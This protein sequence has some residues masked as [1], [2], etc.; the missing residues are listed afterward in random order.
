MASKAAFSGKTEEG[1]GVFGLLFF[2][3]D[4]GHLV[5][6]QKGAQEQKR[7]REIERR[8]VWGSVIK[9]TFSTLQ[10]RKKVI[11]HTHT[12]TLRREIMEKRAFDHTSLVCGATTAT[13]CVPLYMRRLRQGS[14]RGRIGGDDGGSGGGGG[15]GRGGFN[16]FFVYLGVITCL[17]ANSHVLL[18]LHD[19][20]ALLAAAALGLTEHARKY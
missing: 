6:E 2:A 3:L 9:R 18:L 10:Q 4:G 15:G 14:G 5:E 1:E 19:A 13:L 11:L 17:N 16:L 12:F 20:H 8:D 7:E